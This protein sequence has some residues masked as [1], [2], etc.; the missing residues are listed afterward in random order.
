MER[1]RA[2]TPN[3]TEQPRFWVQVFGF[4]FSPERDVKCERSRRH[5]GFLPASGRRVL[6]GGMIHLPGCTAA[7]ILPLR[8]L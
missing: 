8:I 2:P 1:L 4:F 5:V 6:F 3:Q 7:L